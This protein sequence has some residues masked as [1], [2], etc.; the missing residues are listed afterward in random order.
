MTPTGDTAIYETA[1]QPF[2]IGVVPVDTNVRPIR[3]RID[4][5]FAKT[6]W[7]LIAFVALALFALI[8]F[9]L[10]R[11]FARKPITEARNPPGPSRSSRSTS[12]RSSAWRNWMPPSSGSRSA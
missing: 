11:H 12:M 10:Y 2:G 1:A 7:A 4:V 8:V 3:E 6:P 5:E 9:L